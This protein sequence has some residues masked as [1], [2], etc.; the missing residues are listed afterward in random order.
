MVSQ[1][2]SDAVGKNRWV[3]RAQGLALFTIAYNLIEGVV[4]VGFGIEEASWALLGF[5][6]DSFVEVGSA[7]F[8][9]W[10]FQ[11]TLR[12]QGGPAPQEIEREKKASMAIAFLFVILALATMGGATHQLTTTSH[13]D[14]TWPGVIVAGL[15]L[16]F[17]FALWRA[18]LRVAA[19]LN[20][21]VMASDAACSL[22]CI[23]LSTI[24]LVGS[25]LFALFPTLWWVDAVAALVLGLFIGT[26]GWEMLKAARQPDFTG[27]CGCG[28]VCE[29][30]PQS[31]EG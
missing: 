24:L 8:V 7:A 27:G 30:E 25:L 28:Q 21:R 20:S 5:G 13:P 19:E 31:R 16:S 11:G 15:S 10:R 18:K 6:M 14:T 17:M 9:L 26:E 22:A 12:S 2:H 23:K 29:P 3:R 4:S 1:V